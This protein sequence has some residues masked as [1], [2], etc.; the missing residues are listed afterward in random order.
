MA[1]HCKVLIKQELTI[2]LSFFYVIISTNYVLLDNIF[3]WEKKDN[4]LKL[5]VNGRFFTGN[6]QI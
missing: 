5:S 6:Y 2:T 1:E 4:Y 3:S